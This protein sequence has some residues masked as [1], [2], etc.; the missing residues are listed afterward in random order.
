MAGMGAVKVTYVPM[1]VEIKYNLN[2]VIDT[3][4]KSDKIEI[5]EPH[6]KGKILFNI[7]ICRQSSRQYTRTI[8]ID[9]ILTMDIAY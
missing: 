7:V 8:T 3:S 5:L 2:Q 6:C 9:T 1:Y 4:S